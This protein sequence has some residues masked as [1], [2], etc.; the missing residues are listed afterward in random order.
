MIRLMLSPVENLCEQ[1]IWAIN[2]IIGDGPD[3][4]NSVIEMGFVQVLVTFVQP[5]IPL[6]ILRNVAWAF[7]NLCRIHNPPPPIDA[8]IEILPALNRLIENPDSNILTDTLW[9]LSYLTDGGIDS[10]ELVID[11]GV[12]LP[13]ITFL[14]HADDKI[15]TAALRAIGNI[16]TGSDNQTQFVLNLDVLAFVPA[17]L[18]HRNE[19][20]RK[21][22]VW[23]LSN[24]TAGV[25]MQIQAVID[26]GLLPKIIELLSKDEISIKKEAAYVICNATT[27][28]SRQQVQQLVQAGAIQALN[29]LLERNVS[30]KLNSVSFKLY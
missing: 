23:F 17:L 30:P 22:A 13:L 2:N 8:V 26:A 7:A 24:I 12:V 15:K 3:L 16:A 9:A 29:Q 28:G 25:R 11:S 21:E 5:H 1:S 27:G 14:S 6:S 18:S 19:K 4:R 10:I 20:I